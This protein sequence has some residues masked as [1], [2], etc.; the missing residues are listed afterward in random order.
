MKKNLLKLLERAAITMIFAVAAAVFFLVISGSPRSMADNA[1]TAT[2]FFLLAWMLYE[3]VRN[4]YKYA[5]KK[6]FFNFPPDQAVL[7][8]AAYVLSRISLGCFL[9]G[10]ALVGIPDTLTDDQAG[11]LI[12]GGLFFGLVAA[13]PFGLVVWAKRSAARKNPAAVAMHMTQSQFVGLYGS[14][15]LRHIILPAEPLGSYAPQAVRTARLLGA[16]VRTDQDYPPLGQLIRQ[17]MLIQGDSS[18]P[19]NTDQ[20][21]AAAFSTGD[22]LNE[23][24]ERRG[25]AA[26]ISHDDWREL[27]RMAGD[28]CVQ[29]RLRDGVSVNCFIAGAADRI[30]APR[31][32]AVVEILWQNG[33]SLLGVLRDTDAG[34]LIGG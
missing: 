31:G 24:L 14:G 4:L 11:A 29:N 8:V 33:N 23:L 5:V 3:T 22:R 15:D 9:A 1:L 27:K 18:V 10:C 25:F 17:D 6:Q 13:L 2:L 19:R 28:V 7:A 32:L 26:R 20:L 16:Y 34:Q 12:G 30:L 21:M